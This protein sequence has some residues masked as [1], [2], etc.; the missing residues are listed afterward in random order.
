MSSAAGSTN[1]RWSAPELIEP[2][3]IGLSRMA[4]STWTDIWSFGML[5]LELMTGQQPFNDINGDMTV[6][7]A[8]SKWQLPPRPGS[9]ASSRG[10]TDDL[11]ALLL[12]CWNKD[13][14]SRP[15]M[16]CIR[17]DMKTIRD[18]STKTGAHTSALY[19]DRVISFTSRYSTTTY[20]HSIS[21][22]TS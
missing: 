13:P 22:S 5:C 20:F 18:S 15:T 7:I 14:K 3:L 9:L 10:L 8:L 17:T 21:S 4:S 19:S 11:W 12:K 6:I 2:A 16:S 1:S